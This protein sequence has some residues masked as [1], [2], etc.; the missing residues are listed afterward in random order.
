MGKSAEDPLMEGRASVPK[1]VVVLRVVIGLALILAILF[2]P[3]GTLRWPQAW[4]FLLLY[5]SAVAWFYLYTKKKDPGLLKERMS[6]PKNV[7]AWDRRIVRIYSLLLALMTVLA[8]LD[9]VRFRWSRLSLGWNI[10]GFGGLGLAMQLAFWATRENT[11]ASQVVRIQDDR[12][13]RVCSTGPYAH[14]RHP[15][16]VG[17][18]LSIISFPLA[19]GSLFAFIPAG[20]IVGLFVL[21]TSLEDKTLQEQLP[22]YKEYAQKVRS[23]LIPGVW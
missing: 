17:V 15:M 19:L 6:P 1:K 8:G 2:I 14:V 4:I 7:K 18:I 3:A 16:Y 11:F 9:A 10:L 12:G 23:R 20:L 22:G 21:R 13:H 5:F